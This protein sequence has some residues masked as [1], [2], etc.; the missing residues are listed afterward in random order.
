MADRL[1][2]LS[3]GRG[4]FSEKADKPLDKNNEGVDNPPTAA[5]N[6]YLAAEA[7]AGDVTSIRSGR[8]CTLTAVQ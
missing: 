1:D 2:A 8:G 3:D 5:T 6:G 4:I 7:T